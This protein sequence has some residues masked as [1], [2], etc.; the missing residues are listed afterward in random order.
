[1]TLMKQPIVNINIDK[2]KDAVKG[3]TIALMMNTSALTNTGKSLIDIMHFDWDMNIKFLLGMEHG[4]RGELQGGVKVKNCKDPVTGLQV[5]S[6]YD[7][8]G[9]RPP[10]DLISQVDAVVF[11]AQDAGVRHYTYTPWMMFAMDAAAKGGTEI[12]VLDR[13]NPMGGD[14]VEGGVV[15]PKHFSIIGG[16]AYPYRHGM[17][18]G[19]LALMYNDKYKIGCNLTVIP[20]EGWKR[21]MWYDETG[22]LWTPPSPNIPV[23]D[24][25]TAYAT[26]G[27][28]QSTNVSVGIGTTTPFNLFGAPWINGRNLAENINKLEFPGLLCIDKYFIPNYTQYQGQVCSGVMLIC[29]DRLLYRPVTAALNILSLIVSDYSDKFNFTSVRSYDD[30]AGSSSLRKDLLAGRPAKD[31]VSDWET[32]ADKFRNERIPYLLY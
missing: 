2:L 24:T 28:L 19:E 1:M 18:I 3:K 31:I 11:C 16:F 4:V 23:L 26:V 29:Y 5:I 10:A 21:S 17:T 14:I 32:Q 13:P 20:M 22:L 7:F 30:R 6:L 27:L 12:I 25:L 9:L 15:E 8:P